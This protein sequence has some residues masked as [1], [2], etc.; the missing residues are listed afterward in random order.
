MRAAFYGT[1]SLAA[2]QTH[3]PVEMSGSVALGGYTLWC[4]QLLAGVSP[5]R[6]WAGTGIQHRRFV[7]SALTH[8]S[9][10]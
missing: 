7:L 9:G 5:T 3:L 6:S 2:L 4:S 1:E 10:F 8:L